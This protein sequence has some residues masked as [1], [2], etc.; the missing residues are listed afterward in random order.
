MALNISLALA[1]MLGTVMPQMPRGLQN[2]DTELQQFLTAG[3]G[4]YGALSDFFYWAGFYDLYNSLWFRMLVVVVVF[5]IVACTLNRWQ[6]IRRQISNPTVRVSDSF[7]NGLSEKAQFRAVPLTADTASRLLTRALNRSRYRV[8]SESSVD[9]STYHI[10]ADRDRWSKLVTFVSHG[11]LVML[12]VTAAGLAGFSWR[13]Q[14]VTLYPGQAVNVGHGTDFD[15]RNDGFAIDFYGD[16]VTVKQ[17]MSSVTV[18]E[19]GR[20]VLSRQISV[21][22][23]LVYKGINFFLS[24]YQPVVYAQVK[25]ATGS[26]VQLGVLGSPLRQIEPVGETLVGFK[27]RSNDNLPMDILRISGQKGLLT[28]ELTYRQDVARSESDNPP[29]YIRAS[30]GDDFEK[31]VYDALLP[32]TGALTIP[33]FEQYAISFRKD[34]AVVLEVAQDPGLG[35]VGMFFTVMAAG[36]TL[37]LYTTYTRCWAKISPSTTTPGACDITIC[38]LAD[39]NKVSF[40]RDFEKLVSNAYTSFAD[41]TASARRSDGED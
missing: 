2:F 41:A 8:L 30:A 19:G 32:P 15:V 39:K 36:F 23:P 24:S 17:Y 12:V 28:L 27:I 25:D 16:G 5:G 26:P 22:N 4:R 31:P 38:G 18:L 1:A 14:A 35:L 9:G 33:G 7:L 20:V 37:S 3:R 34:T 6:P 10:Y 29:L 40:E 13:E 21:N 11:A